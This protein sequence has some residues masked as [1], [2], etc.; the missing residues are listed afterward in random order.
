MIRLASRT[1]IPKIET[2]F[3]E[4]F[5]SDKDYLNMVFTYLFP[6]SECYIYQEEDKVSST[7]FL[8][9][10]KYNTPHNTYN[11]YYLYGVATLKEAEGKGLAQKLLQYAAMEATKK[12]KDFIICRPAEQSLVGYYSKL[13]YNIHLSKVPFK[14]SGIVNMYLPTPQIAIQ[15]LKGDISK[16]PYHFSWSDEILEYMFNIGEIESHQKTQDL[17]EECY[18]LLNTLNK[19]IESDISLRDSLFLFPME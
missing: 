7:L 13:N 8:I 11:G 2:I 16:Y 6:L 12:D 17:K 5:T 4:R 1:D 18:I 9:P 15:F 3:K 10:I 19:N 14:I